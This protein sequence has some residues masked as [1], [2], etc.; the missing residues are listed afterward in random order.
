MYKGRIKAIGTV[1]ELLDQ[2]GADTLENAFILLNE[3][4]I[5]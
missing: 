2:T 4:E 1:G 5:I 3:R